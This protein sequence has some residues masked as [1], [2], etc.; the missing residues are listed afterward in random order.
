MAKDPAKEYGIELKPCPF[1]GHEATAVT[2]YHRNTPQKTVPWFG[3]I[4]C[5]KC[6]AQMAAGQMMPNEE[7]A[8]R[9][10]ATAW[11]KRIKEKTA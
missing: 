9:D 4:Q 7:R 8:V 5:T 3:Y 1:C 10:A 6:L 2:I 11:N